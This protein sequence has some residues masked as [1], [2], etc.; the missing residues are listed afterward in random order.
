MSTPSQ[1]GLGIALAVAF[2][3]YCCPNLFW[4][5]AQSGESLTPP[6]SGQSIT[7]T[8]VADNEV[9]NTF[10][11]DNV[12][13]DADVTE[14]IVADNLVTVSYIYKFTSFKFCLLFDND[15]LLI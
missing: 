14:T 12:V 3:L 2:G 5:N 15:W 6:I 9:A 4:P 11:A 7:D 8:V 13:A 1:L 10:V